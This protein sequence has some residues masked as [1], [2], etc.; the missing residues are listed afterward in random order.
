MAWYN[1]TCPPHNKSLYENNRFFTDDSKIEI[2]TTITIVHYFITFNIIKNYKYLFFHKL[3]PSNHHCIMEQKKLLSD[4]CY[5][6]ETKI[7]KVLVFSL[8]LKFLEIT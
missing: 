5:E 8:N 1:A 2:K 6:I 4:H 3:S 7:H